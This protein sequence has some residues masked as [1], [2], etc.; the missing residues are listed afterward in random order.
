MNARGLSI[1]GAALVMGALLFVLV[2]PA[3]ALLGWL[4]AVFLWS[5]VP[6]GSLGLTMTVRLT[7][8]RWGHAAL[9]WLEAGM[10]TWPLALALL[11]PIF[12]GMAALY[13]WVAAPATGFKGA[14][15]APV[16]FIAR[17][18]ILFAG[19][20]LLTWLLATRRGSAPV[21]SSAGLIFLMV[22]SSLV[23][24]DWLT[25]LDREFHSSGLALYAIS[26]QYSV[27]WLVAVW[28]L[29]GRQPEQTGAVAAIMITFA[30][31]GLYLAFTDYFI[32]WSGN[33]ASVAGWYRV[34]AAGGW[35]VLYGIAIAIEAGAFLLLLLP[36]VRHEAAWLRSLAAVMIGGKA[37]EAAWFTL[38]Q[39]GAVQAVTITPFLVA[40]T[41]IGIAM[42]SAQSL[43]LD[44]RVRQRMPA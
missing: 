17:S 16:P 43:L 30:L 28:L 3:T 8:G 40:A 21:I 32:V 24:T 6:L 18:L 35:P 15:L 38:P 33:L 9:P 20:G 10:L 1:L 19:A 37:I 36:R 26:I 25:S 34:R 14:W 11:L 29:L 23:M 27:A 12:A 4:A 22:V 42:I 13:P 39:A 44:R 31:V 2:M 41:G 5:G 7:G